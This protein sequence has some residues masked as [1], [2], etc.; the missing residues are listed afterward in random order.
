MFLSLRSTV[1]NLVIFVAAKDTRMRDLEL[2]MVT[3]SYTVFVRSA[4][5][6]R[7]ASVATSSEWTCSECARF[8]TEFGDYIMVQVLHIIHYVVLRDRQE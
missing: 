2:G 3:P 7:L 1:A 4:R 8:T 6:E 5:V